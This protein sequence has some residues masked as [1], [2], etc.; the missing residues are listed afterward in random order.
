MQVG[1]GRRG[2]LDVNSARRVRRAHL[3][4]SLRMN[5]RKEIRG[6]HW[7]KEKQRGT[8]DDGAQF[9]RGGFAK[10][11]IGGYSPLVPSA[12]EAASLRGR[13]HSYRVGR[14]VSAALGGDQ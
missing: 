13:I 14:H 4:D 1:K 6:L 3:M 8:G 5:W 10:R 7:F 2:K 9:V 11:W 12:V